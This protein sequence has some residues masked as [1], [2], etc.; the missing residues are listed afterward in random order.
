M[1]SGPDFSTISAAM[2]VPARANM[3]TALMIGFALTA[4]E[5][6]DEAGVQPSTASEH[7]AV[8][9]SARLI[10]CEK[11]G[12]HRYFRIGNEEVAAAIE[13]LQVA[14]AANRILRVR[15]GPNDPALRE[16]RICYDHL[17]GEKGVRLYESMIARGFLSVGNQGVDLSEKGEVFLSDLGVDL[18]QLRAGRRMLCRLC[19]DWSV[20][21]HHLAGAAGAAILDAL[22]A[23]RW[24]SMNEALECYHFQWRGAEPLTNYFPLL[25]VMIAVIQCH[26]ISLD[27]N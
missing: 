25:Q 2:G 8:L 20:R 6:A 13:A 10:I 27:S 23:R 1:K 5:L 21:R 26:N 11:Q 16:A 12:R 24:A 7:L 14:A 22:L 18:L 19:L 17:A 4:R 3:L 15:P 9:S